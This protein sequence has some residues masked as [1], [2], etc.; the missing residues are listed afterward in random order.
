MSA[1]TQCVRGEVNFTQPTRLGQ[2]AEGDKPHD[3]Q[4]PSRF[5]GTEKSSE[6][7]CFFT[8]LA[9]RLKMSLCHFPKQQK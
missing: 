9:N 7:R 1:I 4:R 3:A 6:G 8:R 5:L 2:M